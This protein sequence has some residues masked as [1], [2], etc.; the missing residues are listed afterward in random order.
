MMDKSLNIH[1]DADPPQLQEV[2]DLSAG[3]SFADKDG[4]NQDVLDMA[5][6]GKIQELRVRSR[7]RK[8][9]SLKEILTA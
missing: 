8:R 4:A 2:E 5:R 1:T 7:G 6:M 9:H 3:K